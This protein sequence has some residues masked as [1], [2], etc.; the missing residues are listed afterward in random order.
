MRGACCRSWKI[1][2]GNTV[3]SHFQ[4]DVSALLH[5]LG[6]PHSME[7]KTEARARAPPPPRAP[8]RGRALALR[9]FVPYT[10]CSATS[11]L[12]LCNVGG[13]HTCH[14]ADERAR[15]AALLAQHREC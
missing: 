6:V 13:L 10:G 3:V 12:T 5:A 1:E 15:P 11:L 14:M 4:A 9:S 7:Y 2:V 8:S